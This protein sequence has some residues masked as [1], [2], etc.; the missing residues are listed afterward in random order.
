[1][2]NI[3][4]YISAEA[5]PPDHALAELTE[6]CS[7]LCVETLKAALQ[8]VHIIYVAVRQGRGL[9]V[10]TEVRYRLEPFRT[11]P[12]MEAFMDKLDEAIRHATGLTA[13]IRCFGHTGSTLH[14][15]N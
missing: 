7:R 4:I 11:P 8:N 1:M 2:P 3:T 6:Q 5:M 14:A 10:F 15:R 12:V 13:R 9:P